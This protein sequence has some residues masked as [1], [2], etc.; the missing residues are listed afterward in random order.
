MNRI[1]DDDDE[2]QEMLKRALNETGDLVD[3]KGGLDDIR[4]R[5]GRI[6]KGPFAKARAR[7]E[8]N[9]ARKLINQEKKRRRRR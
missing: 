7:R 5:L 1:P 3:P 8:V 2:F 4:Q 6:K 9:K